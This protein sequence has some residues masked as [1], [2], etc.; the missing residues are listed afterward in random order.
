MSREYS[1]TSRCALSWRAG[2]SAHLP[3]KERKSGD[4]MKKLQG[5]LSAGALALRD[6]TWQPVDAAT[7]VCGDIVRV[8]GGQYDKVPADIRITKTKDMKVRSTRSCKFAYVDPNSHRS[9]TALS[10]ARPSPRSV[11]RRA[12]MTIPL[13]RSALVI[14]FY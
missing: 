11:A 1:R 12:R 13:V 14:P 3:K 2:F 9:T 8:G 5:L 6:G 7:L 10:P 4:A